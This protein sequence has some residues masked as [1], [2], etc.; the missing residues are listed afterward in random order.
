MPTVSDQGLQS[1]RKSCYKA[2][3]E[4]FKCLEKEGENKNKCRAELKLFHKECP[5]SWVQ[6]FLRKRGIDKYK[7]ELVKKG[8]MSEDDRQ[9]TVKFNDD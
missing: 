1:N 2:R 8:I 9:N 4:Y 6:H 7:D 3:D 5:V